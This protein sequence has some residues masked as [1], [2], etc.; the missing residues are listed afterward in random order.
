MGGGPRSRQRRPGGLARHGVLLSILAVCVEPAVG[1]ALLRSK[2]R[3]GSGNAPVPA[4]QQKTLAEAA[5]VAYYS[6]TASSFLTPFSLVMSSTL[7][8]AIAGRLLLLGLSAF[9]IDLEAAPEESQ[10]DRPVSLV[11]PSVLFMSSALERKVSW[12]YIQGFTAVGQVVRPLVDAGLDTPQGLA[13]HA[14]TN[15]LFVADFG[16]RKIFR[17]GLQV[18]PCSGPSCQGIDVEVSVKGLQ[19]TIV[20]DVLTQFVSVDLAGNL[21]F[22]DE[23]RNTVCRIEAAVVQ[24][25]ADRKVYAEDLKRVPVDEVHGSNWKH[26]MPY[27]VEL[28]SAGKGAPIKAPTGV[29]TDGVSV[30]WANGDGGAA[31]EGGEGGEDDGGAAAASV[32]SGLSWPHGSHESRAISDGPPGRDVA[33]TNAMVVYSSKAGL[34]GICNLN[35]RTVPLTQAISPNGLIWDGDGTVYVADGV[36]SQVFSLATGVC[37]A[38]RPLTPVISLH[39]VFGVALMKGTDPALASVLGGPG[40]RFAAKLFGLQ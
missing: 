22:T 10:V 28:Y 5:N 2:S 9:G 16:Q 3:A 31:E 12:C 30:A 40:R 17:Y 39:D 4:D 6:S 15:A 19:Q 11:P 29:D 13:Y 33:M 20:E 27:I 21:Y 37:K 23:G 24:K 8:M 36:S 1:V 7:D 18:T 25:V 14:A 26:G 38:K 34:F 32:A 35:G